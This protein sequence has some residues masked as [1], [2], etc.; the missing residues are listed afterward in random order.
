VSKRGHADHAELAEG[1]KFTAASPDFL[2]PVLDGFVVGKLMDDH[3]VG[4]RRLALVDSKLLAVAQGNTAAA[5]TLHRFHDL[6]YHLAVVGLGVVDGGVNDRIDGHAR[7]IS[8][9]DPL[10]ETRTK[11]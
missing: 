4:V 10:N 8:K 9:K 2:D 11:R 1:V 3:A 7:A 5:G 6:G